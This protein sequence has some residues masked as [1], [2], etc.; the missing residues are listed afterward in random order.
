MPTKNE[1]LLWKSAEHWLENIQVGVHEA[2]IND[3]DCLLCHEYINSAC[4]GCPV[5][6]AVDGLFCIGSPW[7]KV[8]DAAA[9][10]KPIA[11]RTAAIAEYQFLID[12]AFK[13]AEK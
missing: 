13:E 7:E 8:R 1:A 3:V 6:D 12:L 11:F 2:R 9:H 5:R 4:K 10:Q